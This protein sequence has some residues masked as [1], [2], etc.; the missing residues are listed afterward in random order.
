MKMQE[1]QSREKRALRFDDSNMRA[2]QEENRRVI[3]GYPILF[4]VSGHPYLG[5]EW[6]E[7]IDQRALEGVDLS[8]LLL[9]L[10]HDTGL[11]LA[12]SGK[13]MRA[14]VDEVGLFI[15]ADLG[16]TQL[17]DYA[18]D[19]VQ[20]GILDGMSFWFFADRID[21]DSEKRVDRI[22]HITDVMEVSLVAFPAYPATVAVAM[23]LPPNTQRNSD[24]P[25]TDGGTDE[26]VRAIALL[27]YELAKI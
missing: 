24:E 11:I 25:P 22:M 10:D 2:V 17:D 16:D 20:R 8:N 4:N 9:L 3:R 23:D 18:F 7:V 1:K 19:R 5:S 14:Q 21:Q 6:T 15:E 26:Q 27:D 13:N 12:R